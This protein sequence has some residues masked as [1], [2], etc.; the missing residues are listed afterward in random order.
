[1]AKKRRKVKPRP[2]ED[3]S[4]NFL[5]DED[6]DEF[7][8][9]A[10][11]KKTA[12]KKKTSTKKKTASGSDEIEEE[13]LIGQRKRRKR[14]THNYDANS[15]ETKGKKKKLS[16]KAKK[17]LE[18]WQGEN[19]SR[20]R[21]LFFI[22][23]SN[24]AKAKFGHHSVFAANEANALV[25]GIPVPCLGIEWLLQQD[26]LP[27]SAVLM[28]AGKWRT[29]KSALLYEIFRWFDKANGG[30]I[31]MENETKY[32]PDLCGS[33]MGFK[34]GQV[35]I[36]VNRCTSMDDWQNRLTYYVKEQKRLL[37]GTQEEPGP[38]R[39]IPICFAVDSVL[40]KSTDE[41]KSR[42]QKDGHS[43]KSYPEEARSLTQYLQATSDAYDNWPFS[44][45]MVNHLK[46]EITEDSGDH[47]KKPGGDMQS[48]Q[49]SFEF[50]TSTW[51]GKIETE[52]FDGIGVRIECSKNSLG[53]TGRKIKTRMLWWYEWDEDY[54]DHIQRTVWD[55]D[56]T[57]VTTLN[58]LPNKWKNRLKE[59]GFVLKVKSP[60]A[61][62]ECLAN[63]RAVGMAK[64]EYL[65]FS[66]VGA[67]IR[68]NEE[69]SEEI[70][71]ALAIK[72]RA[73]MEGD[74]LEQLN[75]LTEELV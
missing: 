73:L 50:I 1:M 71:I 66:E 27:L 34:P 38:G 24:I 16:K 48:F 60:M 69:L 32:S 5:F 41:T 11:T 40:G 67:L 55:W 62:V 20:A 21:D 2:P 4:D 65:T 68:Q 49:A 58:E 59:R 33:I 51:R 22:A 29:C 9:Q 6:D 31:L 42:I 56:W 12:V 39:T 14:R 3:D 36:I 17:S 10:P 8:D 15:P 75:E 19:R 74:Y 30:A 25:I 46:K 37:I 26:V 61:D 63:C 13:T 35:P 28:I 54:E 23:Q 7:E 72:R 18:I 57:T 52:H 47:N 44:L 45:A 53:V 43:T 70:R 64:D